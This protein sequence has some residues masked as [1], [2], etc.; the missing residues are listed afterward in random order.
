M[1]R[2]SESGGTVG[3]LADFPKGGQG[4]KRY[5]S[6]PTAAPRHL[7]F[8]SVSAASIDAGLV[9]CT[10]LRH[11]HLGASSGGGGVHNGLRF[12]STNQGFHIVFR[13]KR[14]F[15]DGIYVCIW[16]QCLDVLGVVDDVLYPVL[17]FSGYCKGIRYENESTNLFFRPY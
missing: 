2:C 16:M 14:L 7:V 1:D 5:R 6:A 3:I 17:G 4:H 15:G 11:D 12:V 9:S 8:E 13:R 10:L